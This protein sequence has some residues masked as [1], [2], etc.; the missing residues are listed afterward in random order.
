MSARERL[1]N[2]RRSEIA[3]FELDGTR[4]RATVSRFHDGRLAEVFI[5]TNRPC[6][7]VAIAARDIGIAASLALQSGCPAETLRK[8]LQRLSDGTPAGPLAAALDLFAEGSR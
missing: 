4:F 5:D 1:P 2:R 8:A 7:G 6:S 3:T